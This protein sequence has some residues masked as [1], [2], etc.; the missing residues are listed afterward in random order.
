MQSLNNQSNIPLRANAIYIGS[1][2]DI[3]KYQN[4]QVNLNADTNCEI[5]YYTSNDKVLIES[6]AFQYNANSNYFNSINVTSRYVYFTVRNLQNVNQNNFNFSV[7]Y[8][9][10]PVSS[11]S[12]GG[13]VT[14]ISPLI[15][16]SVSVNLN[17][18]NSDFIDGGNNDGLKVAIQ[19]ESLAI[20]NASLS[21]M[22]FTDEQLNVS[23]ATTHTTL[24][25]IYN[26]VNSRGSGVFTTENMGAASI[27]NVINLSNLN[28]KCLTIYGTVSEA[29]TLTVV[30]SPNNVIGYY[31]PSQY[32]YEIA[33]A[34]SFGFAINACPN[35]ICLQTSNALTKLEAFI[36]YS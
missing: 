5:L 17:A 10:F 32:S 16:D 28:V 1:W 26:V 4:I 12:G 27:T 30:F 7:L 18:I 15:D 11:G 19:N 36:D 31:Y 29:T 33:S 22:T 34:G 35:Y 20:T 21:D 14:I 8:K 6:Q 13:D 9:D 25:N 2:D 24:D 23:D 3:L